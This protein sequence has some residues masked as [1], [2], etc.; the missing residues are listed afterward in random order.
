MNKPKTPFHIYNKQIYGLA[1]SIFFYFLGNGQSPLFQ[2]KNLSEEQGLGGNWVNSFISKDSRGFVWISDQ[3]GFHRFDGS[4]LEYFSIAQQDPSSPFVEYIQS[5][6]WEDYNSDLWFSTVSAVHRLDRDKNTYESIQFEHNG[7]LLDKY[8]QVFHYD[9]S[10]NSLWIN[11]NGYMWQYDLKNRAMLTPYLSTKGRR[12]EVFSLPSGKTKWI[13]ALPWLSGP[14]F[15][16]WERD[17]NG[18]WSS[19]IPKDPQ[20]EITQFS[21]GIFENDSTIWLLSTK[22]GVYEFD[23]ARK[24]LKNYFSPNTPEPVQF[25]SGVFI[26]PNILLLSS[27]KN[28]LWEFNTLDQSFTNDW[29]KQDSKSSFSLTSNQTRDLYLD[30]NGGLWITQLNAGVDY[31]I[32]QQKGFFTPVT[33]LQNEIGRVS[34]MVEDD[35]G[36]I[37]SLTKDT[38]IFVF[39]QS[40]QLIRYF[41]SILS[42]DIRDP[43]FTFLNKDQF[44]NIWVID[45]QGVYRY[46]RSEDLKSGLWESIYSERNDF[47][48]I[49]HK[50]GGPPYFISHT[51]VYK[52]G[53]DNSLIRSKEF[54]SHKGFVFDH[55][56]KGN[57]ANIFIPFEAKTLWLYKDKSNTMERIREFEIGTDIHAITSQPNS[58]ST[59]I[60]TGK[61]LYLYSEKKLNL[62]LGNADLDEEITIYSVARDASGK[63]WFTTREGLWRFTPSSSLLIK[64][65]KESGLPWTNFS[66]GSSLLASDGKIWLGGKQGVVYFNPDSIPLP[67]E[68]IAPKM[69]ISRIWVNGKVIH[70]DV[71]IEELQA[72]ELPNFQNTIELE[73][74]LID[75]FQPNK[76]Q[77][78]YRLKGYEARWSTAKHGDI[79]RFIKVPPGRYELQMLPINGHRLKGQEKHFS[80]TIPIPYWQTVW[81]KVVIILATLLSVAFIVGAFYRRKLIKQRRLL[82]KQKA[83]N[84]ERN[85]IARELHDDMGSSLSS[86]LFL[87]D[88]LMVEHGEQTGPEIKRIANL[89]ENSLENMKEIVWALDKGKNNL[90]DLSSRLRKFAVELLND[91]KINYEFDLPIEQREINS[92]TKRN[93]YLISKEALHNVV[94]HAE[95]QK[96]KIILKAFDKKLLLMIQDD[97][98]GIG[99]FKQHHE[100]FGLNNIKHRAEVLGGTLEIKTTPNSGTRIEVEVPLKS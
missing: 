43:S 2:F 48:S 90:K 30:D 74:R 23:L 53:K 69:Y 97:G 4:Q 71:V 42:N 33:N 76:G 91:S 12:F 75:F 35:F 37:W 82:E 73:L 36:R 51:G 10:S 13:V 63:V 85:R 77:I 21:K 58:D 83:L 55:F 25:W 94:K 99:N 49:F 41:P 86:I 92:E 24:E 3:Y 93:I 57:S 26:K 65:D 61:G 45:G 19:I 29:R 70:S 15:E 20:L 78:K 64:Y 34:N 95:A 16:I 31:A 80:I 59:W 88:D 89:A 1:V 72:I 39:D 96:V 28:G 98:K 60:A 62:V 11:A 87:S 84:E 52:L 66:F 81:F 27:K 67:G 54:A 14:G 8:N 46:P 18:D 9:H 7:G 50:P 17:E 40:G 6:V 22:G 44:G 68:G 56:F 5:P 38:G 79:V 47:I 32:A 100:G